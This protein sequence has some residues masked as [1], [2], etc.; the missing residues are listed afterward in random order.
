VRTLFTRF[1]RALGTSS[2]ERITNLVALIL[3]AVIPTLYAL[4][5]LGQTVPQ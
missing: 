1:D 5:T 2:D 4:A 3:A